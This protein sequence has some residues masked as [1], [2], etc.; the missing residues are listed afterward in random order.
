MKQWITGAAMAVAL[1][2]FASQAG[3][4]PLAPG[5]SQAPDVFSTTGFTLLASNTGQALSSGTFTATGSAWVYSD[6][7]NTFCPGC[8][9]FVYQVTR[10]SGTDPIEGLNAG[11]FA[12]FL[13]DAGYVAGANVAPATVNRTSGSGI[14]VGFVFGSPGTQITGTQ[15][16]DLLVVET[17]TIYYAPG[18]MTV[19]DTQSANGAA[20]IPILTPE[21][22]TFSLL[23]AGLLGLGLLRKRLS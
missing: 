14:T 9:D 13:T 22:M 3:A 8:L 12:G 4:T 18:N 10:I 21:P 19:T 20:F 6:S 1:V 17:N 7:A 15:S 16:S 23:G 2:G 11:S 5:G